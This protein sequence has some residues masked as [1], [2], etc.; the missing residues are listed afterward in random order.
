VNVYYILITGLRSIS[1][2]PVPESKMRSIFRSSRV[3]LSR[4]LPWLIASFRMSH[5]RSGCYE[6][7]PEICKAGDTLS[8][9]HVSSC[10]FNACC[11]WD[12][13]GDLTSNSMV[14]IHRFTILSL[15]LRHVISRGALVGSRASTPLKFLLSHT[16]RET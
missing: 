16:F 10:D 14:Q 11:S 13:R 9:R 4:R 12:V 5:Q 3:L 1:L 8:S 7:D 15:C 2:S 6:G